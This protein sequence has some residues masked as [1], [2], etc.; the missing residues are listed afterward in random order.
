MTALSSRLR[1]F[2]L[3]ALLLAL[4]PPL[5]AHTSRHPS[6]YDAMA[7]LR[8]R[9]VAA[10]GPVALAHLPPAAVLA[11]LTPNERTWL[12]ETFL[13]FHLD[14]PALVRIVLPADP[15]GDPF[16]L[17]E[18]GF[19][20]TD[21][22][23]QVG[24]G[25]YETWTRAFPAGEVRLGTPSLAGQDDV[26]F[27]VVSPAAAGASLPEVT[28]L[29][30]GQLRLDEVREDRRPYADSGRRI[31]RAP[32]DLV[33]H[34]LIRTLNDRKQD[35]RLFELFRLTR[36]PSSAAPDQI[37]LTWADDP[38]TTQTIRWRTSPATPH[39]VVAWA[40]VDPAA[41]DAFDPTRAT[42]ASATTEPLDTPDV[43]NDP[44]VHLHGATLTGL[45]P[46]TR[47]HYAVGDGTPAGWSPPATFTTAPAAP[48]PFSFIYLGDA[49]NGLTTW[50]NLAHRAV[51]DAPHAAFV[52]LAGDLINHGQERD[53]WDHFFGAARRIFADRPLL[54]AIGNHEAQGGHPTLYLEQLPLRPNGPPDLD[55]GRAYSVDYGNARFI[56]LDSNA[57]AEAQAPW[58]EAQ[59]RDTDATWK[60]VVYHHP[61]YASR[62]GR[63]YPDINRH[64][65]P[66]FDRYHVDLAL[67]GHDHAYLRTHPMRGG[68]PVASPADGTIY[69]IS[70]SGTKMYP[71]G[72]H[73]YTAVGFTEV[74]TYQVLDLHIDGD[75]LHYR[76]YDAEGRVRDQFVIEK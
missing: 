65:V 63:S 19:T 32:A 5:L 11:Q 7:T 58:L 51:A 66:L 22:A 37:V 43:A 69:L 72:D 67:Q 57:S 52:V 39:G 4:V 53:D 21:H 18:R 49:Q 35:G 64:W 13:H 73:A 46:G 26:Y 8:E 47:Y 48:T 29:Y 62:P 75:R 25:D 38:Q 41:P 12:A 71:Q 2:A 50:G 59:L 30:P 1:R 10:V 28:D 3:T 55:P 56:V 45:Q 61:A 36:F 42:H 23:W 16:W 76:A 74:P 6:F 33:G 70:V 17:E 27:V 24:S 68:E 54:P 31:E 34:R 14:R 9:L 60:F 15:D 44:R 40:P 20:R